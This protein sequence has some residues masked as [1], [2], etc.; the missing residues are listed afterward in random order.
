MCREIARFSEDLANTTRTFLSPPMRDA[1]RLLGDWMKSLGMEVRVDQAGNLRGVHKGDQPDAKRLIIGSHLD[2][3][4]N[5]GAFDGVLGAV[6]GIAL[7]EALEGRRLAVAIEVVGF[8]EEEGV[9]F[10]A[11]FI[12]SKALV[13]ELDEQLLERRDKDGI[14]VRQAIA[15]FGLDS[16]NLDD[17]KIGGDVLGYLEFHIEQGPELEACDQGIAVVHSIFGQTRLSVEFIGKANHAGTTSMRL[18]HDALAAAAAWMVEVEREACETQGLVATVGTIVVLP[19]AEN[20]IPG[21]ADLSLDIRHPDN[22]IRESATLKFM[23]IAK[24]IATDRGISVEIKVKNIQPAVPMD[25]DLTDL[26]TAAVR[27]VRSPQEQPLV[28]QSGAGHDAMILAPYMPTG[29]IFLRSP[30]GISHHPDESVLLQDVQAALAAGINVLKLVSS[31]VT[32][33]S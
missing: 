11:P 10:G 5:A 27:A 28:I 19:G 3:V 31:T 30:G 26:L 29:M 20:V 32:I 25:K 8:S 1:H 21:N 24:R 12:G 16:S 7:V 13:G 14:S 6:I 9:R 17:A 15:E 22:S 4:P 33:A 18:R 2:T 23:N